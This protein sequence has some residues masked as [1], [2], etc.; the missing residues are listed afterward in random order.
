MAVLSS[1][2]GEECE[3]VNIV[4]P[5]DNFESF[6]HVTPGS[7]LDKGWQTEYTEFFFIR[8]LEAGYSSYSTS[9]D[10]LQRFNILL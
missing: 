5:I 4:N 2:R 9:L 7:A 3:R 10:I 8:T 6:N 1:S